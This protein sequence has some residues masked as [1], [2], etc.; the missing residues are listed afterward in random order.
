MRITELKPP[1]A[2]EAELCAVVQVSNLPDMPATKEQIDQA[3]YPMTLQYT[4]PIPCPARKTIHRGMPS[5]WRTPPPEELLYEPSTRD[6]YF[7]ERSVLL[8][9]DVDVDVFEQFCKEQVL[10][11][12]VAV[13]AARRGRCV[14]RSDCSFPRSSAQALM[15]AT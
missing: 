7:T 12:Q 6:C 4:F 8:L 2:S 5:A 9:G 15:T 1:E 14:Q 13:P 3:C 10:E 11:I